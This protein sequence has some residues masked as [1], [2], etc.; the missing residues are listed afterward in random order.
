MRAT[1][2]EHAAPDL[3]DL[4]RRALDHVAG[5]IHSFDVLTRPEAPVSTLRK[6]SI[7][8]PE[9]PCND[10]MKRML[11]ERVHLAIIQSAEGATLGLVTLEDLVEELVGDISDEHDEPTSVPG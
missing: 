3:Y 10:V 1:E 8:A 11:R 7:A 4:V 9:A 5:I 6:V 2:A